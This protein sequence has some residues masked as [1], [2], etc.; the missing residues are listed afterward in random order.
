MKG[1]QS[2]YIPVDHY[3]AM[4]VVIVAAL[5]IYFDYGPSQARVFACQSACDVVVEISPEKVWQT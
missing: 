5:L 1:V 4:R 2:H 3:F